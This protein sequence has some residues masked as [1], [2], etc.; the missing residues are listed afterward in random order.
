MKKL[1]ESVKNSH[2]NYVLTVS[3]NDLLRERINCHNTT[4]IVLRTKLIIKSK[5]QAEIAILRRFPL[6]LQS[7][8]SGNPKF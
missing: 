7:K 1:H 5:K 3:R 2:F 4:S 8:F 6:I